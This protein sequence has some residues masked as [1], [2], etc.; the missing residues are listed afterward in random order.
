[1]KRGK[2][3]PARKKVAERTTAKRAAA[4]KAKPAAPDPNRA[5]RALAQR[6][7]DLTVSNDDEAAFA[8]YADTIESKEAN[9]PPSFGIEAI[10]NKF[11]MWRQMAS[12]AVFRPRTVIADGSTIV[13]EWLGTVTLAASGRTVEL[14]EV[15]VHEIEGG[16]IFR[17]RFYYDPAVLQP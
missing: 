10:R 4:A 14:A 15:A 11:A 7:V 17:E 6:I 12:N 16:K 2:A 13:I 3:L 5:L 1:M 8:L 9:N